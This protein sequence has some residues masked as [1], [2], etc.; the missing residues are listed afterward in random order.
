MTVTITNGQV[1]AGANN[2]TTTVNLSALA[3]DT[4]I[5]SSL[6]VS[7]A[8][9]NAF[10]ASGNA[11]TL[12]QDLSEHPSVLVDNGST[13]PIGK[14]GASA[15][16]LAVSGLAADDNGTLTFSDGSHSVT[17]TIT[18]GQVAAGANNT[19]TTVNLSALADDTSITSSL[20]VS[21]AAG[22]AFSASGNAVTL[23]QDL[24]EHP[25]VLVDN[26]STTPIGKAGAS[27]VALAVSGLAADDNGTLTFS[28]G[29]H[30]VTVT[31][32]NGQ[33][34]DSQGHPL[35]T[36]NLAAAGFSGDVTIS[37][38][39]SVSDAEGNHFSATGN[40]VTLDT[41]PPTVAFTSGSENEAKE[42]WT[43]KGTYSDNGG[44]GVQS[45]QVFLGSTSG[46][47]LGIATLSNGN[48]ALT[49]SNNIEDQARLMF[50]ALVTDNAGN[51]ATASITELDPAGVAGSPINLALTDP[52]GG[53][54][55]GP[56]TL[57]FTGV[58]SD[59]SSESGDESRQR[60]VDS[61][62][63]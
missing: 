30:S 38:S 15:V 16:A 12:D 36:L 63:E 28:D 13:T 43:L 17:V 8:A 34:V 25:S 40:T 22:N 59:W 57:T 5:T 27:A 39:L 7:D 14:A 45:V 46:T 52:S 53:Q 60:H 3:D 29:S 1:V 32:T 6:S 24:S 20:S 21:D 19:T 54:A 47:Y 18:N 37:S 33:V 9:G 55:T 62:D 50:V 41:I 26:G 35:S 51:T 44:P 61:T 58:P 11:V 23:D 48:W 42:S 4:S 10:S 49:T 2:T 31:I 56:I